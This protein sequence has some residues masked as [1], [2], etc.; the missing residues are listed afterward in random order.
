MASVC[1]R[2]LARGYPGPHHR[3]GLRKGARCD[4]RVRAWHGAQGEGDFAGN[5]LALGEIKR[6]IELLTA[7]DAEQ[8]GRLERWLDELKSHYHD[9][10]LPVTEEIAEKWAGLSIDQPLPDVDGLLAATALVHDLTMATRNTR[11]FSRSG[12][13]VENPFLFG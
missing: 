8:A 13:S 6:G 1:P 7:R 11:D 12:V 10:I 5:V 4:E 3:E 9:C 2:E